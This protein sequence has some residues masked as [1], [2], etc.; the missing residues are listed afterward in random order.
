MLLEFEDDDLVRLYTEPGFAGVW[1]KDV[2]RA[3]RK[4]LNLVANAA[5]ERDLYAVKSLH[6]EK[7]KGKRSGQS[8]LRLNKQWRLIVQ[9]RD[10]DAGRIVVIKEIVDYH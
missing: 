8:S 6:F 5:D 1:A 9:L 3:F 2:V 4:V 10:S 7:L